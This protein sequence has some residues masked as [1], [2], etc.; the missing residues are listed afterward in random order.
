MYSLSLSH[1]IDV[2]PVGRAVTASSA[3]VFVTGVGAIFGPLVASLA[4]TS[5]GPEGFWWTVALAFTGIGLFALVRLVVRPRIKGESPEPYV[6]VP[7]R[8]AGLIRSVR[9]SGR[10]GSAGEKD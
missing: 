1:V 2:L 5:I 7:A 3:V 8:S 10:G 9:R 4:M 6:A